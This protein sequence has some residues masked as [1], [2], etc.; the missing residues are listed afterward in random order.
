MLTPVDAP[1]D[2]LADLSP[3]EWDN[4]REWCVPEHAALNGD[5]VG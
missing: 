5:L 4:L 1:I 3:A 2:D